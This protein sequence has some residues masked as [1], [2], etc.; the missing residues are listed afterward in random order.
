MVDA[1]SVV[2][3]TQSGICDTRQKERTDK[4]LQVQILF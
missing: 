3:E 1:I 2:V 4:P